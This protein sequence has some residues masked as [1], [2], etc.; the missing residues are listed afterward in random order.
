MEQK[1]R[2]SSL[3]WK[4]KRVHVTQIGLVTQGIRTRKEMLHTSNPALQQEDRKGELEASA[5]GKVLECKSTNSLAGLSFT[6]SRKGE[7]LGK[8]HLEKHFVAMRRQSAAA[9]DHGSLA[10]SSAAS[11][12]CSSP[13]G[14]G[15]GDIQ[16]AR[17]I[18]SWRCLL[19]VQ[20]AS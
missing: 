6:E 20:R 11:R 17:V 5:P 12:T 19:E 2:S 15:L 18:G 9:I 8:S 1:D 13:C 4:R 10:L 3:A 14:D 16:N 7:L